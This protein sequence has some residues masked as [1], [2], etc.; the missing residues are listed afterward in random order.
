MKKSVLHGRVN[1]IS[2]R[3]V[4]RPSVKTFVI[5]SG[6]SVHLRKQSVVIIPRVNVDK[7]DIS[8]MRTPKRRA[9]AA[10][11]LLLSSYRERALGT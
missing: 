8:L 5:A 4:S 1:I 11:H 10:S 6:I 2:F 9:A 3:R 7:A